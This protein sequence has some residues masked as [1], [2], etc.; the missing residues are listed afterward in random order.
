MN[1]EQYGEV[2]NEVELKKYNTYRTNAIVK[3]MIFVND[4]DSLVKLIKYLKDNNIKYRVLGNGSN[5]IFAK[6]Y[7]DEIFIK[8]DRLNSCDINGTTVNVGAGMLISSLASTTVNNNL[9]GLEWSFGIPGTIGGC[10]YNNAG[11]YNS[12][13]FD[14]VVSVTYLDDDN[15]IITKL[16]K[17]IDFGYRD[18]MFKDDN[19]FIILGCE[20]KLDHGSKESSMLL[21]EDRKRRRYE[22][23]PLEY[24]SAGSV[25]RNPKEMYAGELIEKCG[26]KN[27]TIGGATVSEKHANF[28]VNKGDAKGS[29]IV[30]LIELIQKEVYDKY[31][32]ELYLEQEIVR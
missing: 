9:K 25:F 13:I 16:K 18:S 8:I 15:N 31:R 20:L 32:V 26:L 2:L 21:V 3:T 1:L 10:I 4:I 27:K 28:I 23:Q 6:D 17:D 22:S 12:E 19:H 30:S 24:P 29:D 5:I 11:A 14:Y 7:Y